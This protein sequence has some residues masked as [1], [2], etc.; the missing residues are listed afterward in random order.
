MA[1]VMRHPADWL[2]V[3]LVSAGVA[4]AIVPFV[5]E[6]ALPALIAIWIASFAARS[7]APVHQHCHAHL[8]LFRSRAANAVYDAIGVRIRQGPVT[9]ARVLAALADQ[10]EG[11]TG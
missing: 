4:L 5:V 7:I 11:M 10:R 9:R 1:S 6:L 3:G 8:A 2:P